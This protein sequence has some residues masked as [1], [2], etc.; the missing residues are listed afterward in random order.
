MRLVEARVEKA[1]IEA[2]DRN[3]RRSGLERAAKRL[4]IAIA[5]ATGFN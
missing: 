5:E 2:V 4:D 1:L 3:W